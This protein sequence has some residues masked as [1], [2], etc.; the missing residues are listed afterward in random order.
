MGIFLHSYI[1]MFDHEGPAVVIIMHDLT[2]GMFDHLDITSPIDVDQRL[3]YT[4]R[5]L[6]GHALKK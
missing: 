3:T 4:Q 6:I 5:I 1:D 2:S